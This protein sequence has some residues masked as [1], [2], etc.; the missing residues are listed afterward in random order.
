VQPQVTK[1]DTPL[2]VKVAHQGG[3]PHKIGVLGAV[4]PNQTAFEVRVASNAYL[5]TQ[6]PRGWNDFSFLFVRTN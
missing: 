3:F 4:A 1:R 5:A 2:A 6:K